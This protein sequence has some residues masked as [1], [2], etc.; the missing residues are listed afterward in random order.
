MDNVFKSQKS[1]WTIRWIA[2]VAN[3]ISKTKKIAATGSESVK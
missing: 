2:K 3:N 1:K